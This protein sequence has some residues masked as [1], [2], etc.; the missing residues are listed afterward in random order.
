MVRVN[1]VQLHYVVKG[2]GPHTL[3]CIPGAVGTAKRH[4]SAQL[5]YF[6]REGSDYTLVS[7]DGGVV[8]H[9]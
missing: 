8:A 3:L 6:G 7:L 5:D 9:F 1:G 4:C 2:N